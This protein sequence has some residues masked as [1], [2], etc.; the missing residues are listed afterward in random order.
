MPPTSDARGFFEAFYYKEV[1]IRDGLSIDP[2]YD[3]VS[4]ENSCSSKVLQRLKDLYKYDDE[5][6]AVWEFC[7]GGAE[8]EGISAID[9]IVKKNNDWYRV[10]YTDCGISGATDIK[11]STFKGKP[12]ITDYRSIQH[13]EQQRIYKQ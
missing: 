9:T 4:V 7:N 1:F 3:Y 2:K 12:M 8:G 13:F 10:F 6:F 11:V 5:G